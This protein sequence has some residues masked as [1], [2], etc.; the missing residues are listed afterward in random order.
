MKIEQQLSAAVAEAVKTLYGQDVAEAQIQLQKT[1]KEFDGHLTL[2]VFP[3]LRIS[4]K[5]PDETAREIGEYLSAHSPLVE[6]YNAVNGFLN[7]T[8]ANSSWINLLLDI[9][10]AE[11]YGITAAAPDAPLVMIEYSSPN[12]NKPL[13]LATCATTCSAGRCQ[14]S[15]PPMATMWCAPTLSMTAAYTLQIHAG[16]AE[17]RPGR[18]A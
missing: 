12:T 8:I 18:N 2:V 13:H 5:K 1:K 7:L 11:Q 4:R 6:T 15:S 3:L 16:L 17:I 9:H 14:T 10:Q